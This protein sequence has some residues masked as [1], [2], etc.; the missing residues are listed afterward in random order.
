MLAYQS[1]GVSEKRYNSLYNNM[2]LKNQRIQ[3]LNRIA[4]S[5]EE[6]HQNQ[7]KS[8]RKS[9]RLMANKIKD[10][11]RALRDKQVAEEVA[12]VNLTKDQNRQRQIA[13]RRTNSSLSLTK[14]PMNQTKSILFSQGRYNVKKNITPVR[15]KK[16][17]TVEHQQE[18][19][20]EVQ[21]DE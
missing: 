6:E 17:V 19:P 15:T 20:L 21:Q 5:R 13:S 9:N 3:D 12:K 7:M 4:K 2:F 10:L 8:L 18:K 14:D 1:I 11:E 16:T